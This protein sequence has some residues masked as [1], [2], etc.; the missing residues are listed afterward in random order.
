MGKMCTERKI[1]HLI[2]YGCSAHLLNLAENNVSPE[3]VMRHIVEVQKYFLNVHQAN[4]WLLDCQMKHKGTLD[5]VKSL[6]TNYHKYR[7]I[8]LE[9]AQNFHPNVAKFLNNLG[10]YHETVYLEKQL[11]IPLLKMHWTNFRKKHHVFQRQLKYGSTYYMAI[12]L[13]HIIAKLMD[14]KFRGKHLSEE[15]EHS[16]EMW[17]AE[18]HLEVLPGIMDFKISDPDYYPPIKHANVVK[19]LSSQKRW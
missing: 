16:A 11:Y 1:P 12:Q 13:L 15:Q 5:C 14:P 17:L 3:T 10:I 19:Q 7:K 8:T 2:T 18:Y 6:F 4:G 9:H